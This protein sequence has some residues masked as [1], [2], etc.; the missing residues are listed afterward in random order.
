MKYVKYIIASLPTRQAWPYIGII[1]SA[2]CSL[3]APPSNK[4]SIT[5][6][7]V[8]LIIKTILPY[9][10]ISHPLPIV[11]LLTAVWHLHMIYI[12]ILQSPQSN[13]I[14]MLA[15]EFSS[16]ESVFYSYI[17]MIVRTT[18]VVITCC[19]SACYRLIF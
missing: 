12:S 7:A 9:R 8:R 10:A 17:P 16:R 4:R 15:L 2:V 19:L 6:I 18:P 13:N 3:F 1:Y 14:I 11:P 5:A